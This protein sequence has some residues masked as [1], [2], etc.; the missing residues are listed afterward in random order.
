MTGRMDRGRMTGRTDL[1]EVS[2]FLYGLNT[3]VLLAN[4]QHFCSNNNII[5]LN[6]YSHG[7]PDG[8]TED[9]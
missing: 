7:R 1:G 9:G 4:L 8:W 5:I 2:F 6:Y 3:Q